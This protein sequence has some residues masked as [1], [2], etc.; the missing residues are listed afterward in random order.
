MFR[1]FSWDFCLIISASFSKGIQVST[2]VEAGKFTLAARNQHS[3]LHSSSLGT[4][5]RHW[6]WNVSMHNNAVA[7][8]CHAASYNIN[9]WTLIQCVQVH[10]NYPRPTM[11]DRRLNGLAHLYI[12]RDIALNYDA[13]VDEFRK[14]NRRL[15]FQ[16][17]K[18][19][20]IKYCKYLQSFWILVL[21]YCS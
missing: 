5:Y 4:E 14:K 17:I 13:V 1:I 15:Q 21:L 2:T 8:L 11:S 12:N 18:L 16:W 9:Q 6:M 19:F 20:K 10:T 7:H 3:A